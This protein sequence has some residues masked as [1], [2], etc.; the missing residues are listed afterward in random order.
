MKISSTTTT[1]KNDLTVAMKTIFL[2][3]NEVNGIQIYN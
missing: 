1:I 2:H 3:D